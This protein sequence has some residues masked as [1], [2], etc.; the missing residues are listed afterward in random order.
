M[1]RTRES[2]IYEAKA[3]AKF[4]LEGHDQVETAKE[5]DTSRK[6]VTYRLKSIGHTYTDLKELADQRSKRQGR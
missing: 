6:T 4:I 5:F 3:M 1:E 2:Y